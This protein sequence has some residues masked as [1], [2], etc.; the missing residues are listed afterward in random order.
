M[1]IKI[2]DIKIKKRLRRDPGDLSDLVNSIHKNGLFNPVLINDKNE[3]LAGYRRIQSVKLLGWTEIEYNRINAKSKLDKFNV[4][5]DEN[6]AR[7]DF[8]YEELIHIEEMK[9]YLNAKGIKKILLWLKM[10]F[11]SFLQFLKGLFSKKKY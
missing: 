5:V 3:L 7:K 10:M 8:S 4:E 9:K 11:K 2:S 6:T 1:K